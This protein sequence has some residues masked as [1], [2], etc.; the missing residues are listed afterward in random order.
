VCPECEKGKL[1]KYEPATFLRITGQSPFVPEQHVMERLRCNTCGAYFT[2]DLPDD[3]QQDGASGQK[4]GYT[5]R[6]LMA[7]GKFYAGTPYY[8]QGSLQSLLGVHIT[9]STIWDQAELLGN[10]GFPVFRYLCNVLAAD[11]LHYE[12]DDT[13]NR[14]VDQKPIEK[15]RRNSDKM[16]TRTGVYTSGLIATTGQ[17]HKIV[18]F[19]TGIGH[20][21]EFIDEVLR[22][23]NPT[24]PPPLIMSDALASNKPTVIKASIQALCNAH[25]RRQFY[26]VLSHFPEEVEDVIERYGKIWMHEDETVDKEMSPPERLAY[27][28]Q[29]SLPVMASL[30][31]WGNQLL[32]EEKVEANSGLG[33]AIRYL[34]KHYEGLTC[35]CRVEGAK[36]DNNVMEGQLKLVV[37]NRKNAGFFKSGTGAAVGDVLT[38]LVATCSANGVNPFDYLNR[39]QRNADDVKAQPKKYLPWHSS[40]TA[41][42]E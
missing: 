17:G 12:M 42:A 23:R 24:A 14:I 9:A 32:E 11:A 28:R 13:T 22:Y 37:L 29:H 10:D 33:K 35:F 5:A 21:G 41:P 4:Y 26:D 18:L 36:L 1:Y 20:A 38:S 6:T 16:Q 8:R 19:D 3:V 30:R 31:E 25:A 7:L 27:H 34:D 15:K 40:P 2:A 39:L